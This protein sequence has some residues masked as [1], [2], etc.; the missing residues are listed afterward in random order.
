[1]PAGPVH[2]AHLD[3]FSVRRSWQVG[4]VDVVVDASSGAQDL[5]GL[6]VLKRLGPVPLQART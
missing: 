2:G 6:V 5:G 3:L 4:R 1:M